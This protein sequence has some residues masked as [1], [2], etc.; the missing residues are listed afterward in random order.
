MQLVMMAQALA[1]ECSVLILDEP[2]AA[3]DYRNQDKVLALLQRLQNEQGMTV[4]FSTHMPQHVVEVAS[5]VLLMQSAT[6]YRFGPVA[7][8]LNAGNLTD[9]YDLPIGRANFEGQ[10][11]HTYAPLFGDA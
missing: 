3:L 1:S 9:L 2:C 8:I 10:T 6:D 11:K 7:E 5:H 4:V